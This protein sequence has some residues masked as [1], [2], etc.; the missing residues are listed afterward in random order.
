MSKHR[1]H[2][3]RVLI[4]GVEHVN[5]R[6][7]ASI[8]DLTEYYI[9]RL[10]NQGLIPGRRENAK[11]WFDPIAVKQHLSKQGRLNPTPVSSTTHGTGLQVMNLPRID[12]TKGI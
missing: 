11:W 4:D 12:L 10:A 6:V 3:D 2:S 7:L 9:R 5:S 8:I 1:K